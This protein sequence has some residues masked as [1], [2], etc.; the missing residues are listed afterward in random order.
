LLAGD[1]PA[2]PPVVLIGYSKGLA[3]IL[4]ALSLLGEE[5]DRVAAVVSVAGVVNGTPLAD[6][7]STFMRDVIDHLPLGGCPASEADGDAVASLSYA[8]RQP[9]LSMHPLPPGPRYFSIAA[10]AGLDG[11]S[12]VNR[13]S[14]KM[15][16]RIDTR[17]DGQ[18]IY[19]DALLP[20]STLLA[21]VRSDHLAVA[22]PIHADD[23]LLANQ[24][25]NR[26]DYPRTELLK[27][28]VIALQD[29]LDTQK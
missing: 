3:D 12:R 23:G 6:D 17:N 2:G 26:N 19:R 18:I 25:L 10:F 4:E 14:W 9:W 24:A 5:A 1:I 29:R 8:H 15:L 22:M 20:G 11:M 27:S 16:S 13:R 28:L 21:F 7:Q